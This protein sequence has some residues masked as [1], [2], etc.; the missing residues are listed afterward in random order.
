MAGSWRGPVVLPGIQ[1]D[2]DTSFM[3][4]GVGRLAKG[5]PDPDQQGRLRPELLQDVVARRSRS[6]A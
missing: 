1:A 6:P 5:F 3:L 4:T 2:P